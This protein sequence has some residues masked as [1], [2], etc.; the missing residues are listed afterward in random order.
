MPGRRHAITSDIV[1]GLLGV[2][3]G[4]EWPVSGVWAVATLLGIALTFDGWAL[5]MAGVAAYEL[6]QRGYKIVLRY[7]RNVTWQ[8][9]SIP[10]LA[11]LAPQVVVSSELNG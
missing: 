8:R 11:K 10:T 6:G 2:M 5:V 9:T 3:I 1:T 7:D 4:V